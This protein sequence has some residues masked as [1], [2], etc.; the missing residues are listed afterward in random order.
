VLRPAHAR[1]A[2]LPRCPPPQV[3]RLAANLSVVADFGWN[4]TTVSD[5]HASYA[6]LNS[7]SRVAPDG[8]SKAIEW[9]VRQAGA[10]LALAALWDAYVVPP[11]APMF[12]LEAVSTGAAGDQWRGLSADVRFNHN[13]TEHG[14]GAAAAAAARQG[15]D[16]VGLLRQLAAAAAA[17]AEAAAAGQQP[18]SSI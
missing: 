1:H 13:V 6:V 5:V 8:W 9:A 16:G 11:S 3:A 17:A 2:P 18:L 12:T 4:A 15:Q 10:R 7:S 14:S